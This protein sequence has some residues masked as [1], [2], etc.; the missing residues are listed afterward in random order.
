MNKHLEHI[1]GISLGKALTYVNHLDIA[2]VDE[3][4]AF[5]FVFMSAAKVK[6]V[7]HLL[8]DAEEKLDLLK[9]MIDDEDYKEDKALTMMLED[10]IELANR[11]YSRLK[12]AASF[13]SDI[14][15]A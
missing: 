13:G 6:T 14:R 7:Q 3:A 10:Q 5:L 4:E 12:Q 9:N 8:W 1:D 11:H 2:N 15:I